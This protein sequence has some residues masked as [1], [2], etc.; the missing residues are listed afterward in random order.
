MQ[1]PPHW[2]QPQLGHA[3]EQQPASGSLTS[4][5]LAE[6]RAAGHTEA[7]LAV[8]GWQGHAHARGKKGAACS[9]AGAAK[10]LG[11]IHG[12]QLR[13]SAPAD[14]RL[15]GGHLL[16]RPG[17]QQC[18]CRILPGARPRQERR[19]EWR[20]ERQKKQALNEGGARGG[21][22]RRSRSRYRHGRSIHRK[23]G[24]SRSRSRDRRCGSKRR[25]ST[26]SSLLGS[27]RAAGATAAPAGAAT[28]AAAGAA[29]GDITLPAKLYASVL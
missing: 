22:K 20:Q 18:C 10:G 24:R 4:S 6:H 14:R 13:H 27:P 15:P 5:S 11:D 25:R 19:R 9:R 23:R 28:A 12:S 3:A 17:R 21:S 8:A 1:L 2:H 26:V 29:A 16:A 7:P